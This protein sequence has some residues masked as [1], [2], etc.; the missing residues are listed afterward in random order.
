M[1]GHVWG[2]N[3]HETTALLPSNPTALI[4]RLA[5]VD[6]DWDHVRAVDVLVVLRSF[7]PKGRPGPRRRVAAAAGLVGQ[8]GGWEPGRRGSRAEGQRS[9]LMWGL[10]SQEA[11][12][13]GELG[14]SRRRV[15]RGLRRV[16][17][18][19]VETC[20]YGTVPLTPVCP[21]RLCACRRGDRASDGVP[22]RLRAAAHGGGGGAGAHGE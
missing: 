3:S 4:R 10:A 12:R 18:N 19:T 14:T 22:V 7:L 8:R 15:D 21:C 2:A 13:F 9:G 16:R 11:G 6:L 17:H 1:C 20:C 5:L